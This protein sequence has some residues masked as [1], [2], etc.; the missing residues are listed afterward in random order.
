MASVPFLRFL[1]PMENPLGFGAA[2]F[3]ELALAA[4]LVGLLVARGPIVT[5][6]RR[7]AG[8]TVV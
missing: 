7:I 4:I 2:D 3:V 1:L 6:A 8:R 5:F